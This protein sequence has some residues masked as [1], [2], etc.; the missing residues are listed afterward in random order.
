MV[1]LKPWIVKQESIIIW[2]IFLGISLIFSVLAILNPS[3]IDTYIAVFFI[4]V[5]LLGIFIYLGETL[6]FGIIPLIISIILNS[7]GS[8]P[9]NTSDPIIIVFLPLI[10]AISC[11]ILAFLRFHNLTL[12]KK[13]KSRKISPFKE[14]N[15]KSQFQNG[16]NLFESKS[17]IEASKIFEN[18][19]KLDSLLPE[20]QGVL[21]NL[22]TRCYLLQLD[23]IKANQYCTRLK[24]LAQSSSYNLTEEDESLIL[25][26]SQA[27]SNPEILSRLLQSKFSQ[28][29]SETPSD[30]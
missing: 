13:G 3:D 22:L 16:L 9:N 26:C 10:S 4:V 24:F 2:E 15:F 5:N 8:F 19:L 29:T 12:F 30:K 14:A 6:L 11:F 25:I 21:L 7:E 1:K 20:I 17:Y 28:E 23:F 27:S 18:L